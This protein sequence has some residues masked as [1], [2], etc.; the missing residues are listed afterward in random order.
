MEGIYI[1]FILLVLS[2]YF[3][4]HILDSLS[5]STPF[6]LGKIKNT[7]V[8]GLVGFLFSIT[9]MDAPLS[10][11]PLGSFPIANVF[12]GMIAGSFIDYLLIEK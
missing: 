9:N 5:V 7:I 11:V 1:V 12:L 6:P 4:P 8:F 2:L 10:G 3:A